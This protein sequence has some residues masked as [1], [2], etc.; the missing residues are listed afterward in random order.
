MKVAVIGGA[1]YAAG[2]LLRLLLQHPA[3]DG[4]C[5]HQPEP[6]GQADRGRASGACPDHER[7]IFRGH[8]GRGGRAG[9]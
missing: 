5:R 4:V 8:T 1:G 9:Q 2:E 6:G 7:A 3:G